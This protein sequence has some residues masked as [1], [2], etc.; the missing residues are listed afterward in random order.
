[1]HVQ[2]KPMSCIISI[3]NK[4]ITFWPTVFA[5]STLRS[6]MH[7]IVLYDAIPIVRNYSM[8]LHI[9]SNHENYISIWLHDIRHLNIMQL[10]RNVTLESQYIVYQ[11]R[12]FLS[13]R[14]WSGED[15]MSSVLKTLAHYVY[16][17]ILPCCN[18]KGLRKKY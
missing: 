1:M 5:R 3:R 18:S 2:I 7:L 10:Q 12:L 6:G 9:T 11:K 17:Y 4:T 16:S 14:L 8:L 15:D 13:L